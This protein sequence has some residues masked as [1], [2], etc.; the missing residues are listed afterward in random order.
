MGQNI[1]LW[2]QRSDAESVVLYSPPMDA[3]SFRDVTLFLAILA[4][5]AGA[6]VSVVTE[7][8]SDPNNPNSW[9]M[10]GSAAA[11]GATGNFTGLAGGM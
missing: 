11:G 1:Q 7:Q 8:S 10:T 3:S 2:Y 4:V 6:T 5:G 9:S